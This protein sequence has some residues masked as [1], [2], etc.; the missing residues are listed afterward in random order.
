MDNGII[1]PRA[2][3]LYVRSIPSYSTA[4]TLTIQLR[5]WDEKNGIQISQF[6]HTTE[7]TAFTEKI[8]TF[9]IQDGVLVNCIAVMQTTNVLY[10]DVFVEVGVNN[11]AV[12]NSYPV[13]ILFSD[14][15]TTNDRLSF[16]NVIRNQ[17]SRKAITYQTQTMTAGHSY[18]DGTN[19]TNYIVSGIVFPQMT[20]NTS[21]KFQCT[22]D[23][24]SYKDL[25]D[26]NGSLVSVACSTTEARYVNL[27]EAEFIS[28]K[29]FRLKFATY[30]SLL[31]DTEFTIILRNY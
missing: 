14:Y 7:A 18:T 19:L 25:Y 12:G 11:Q 17:I 26:A 27:N 4:Y 3:G 9:P 8:Q 15:L 31:D 23:G 28:V 1:I 24:A 6:T 20:T 10:G 16:P 2:S 21:C 29:Y 13:G 5:M 30:E 22:T